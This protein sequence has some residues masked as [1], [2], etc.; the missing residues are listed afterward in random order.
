MFGMSLNIIIFQK[1]N[2]DD[3]LCFSSVIFLFPLKIIEKNRNNR[4][5]IRHILLKKDG[6]SVN[7]GLS[8]ESVDYKVDEKGMKTKVTVGYTLSGT[9]VIIEE[10]EH[11]E[12]EMMKIFENM[13]LNGGFEMLGYDSKS[14]RSYS[15]I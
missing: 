8:V 2:T 14:V 4:Q 12:E 10:P 3:E 9:K 15:V 5:V 7:Y 6:D 11:T 13:M 1:F